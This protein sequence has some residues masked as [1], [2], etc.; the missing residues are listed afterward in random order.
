MVADMWIARNR[1]GSLY[2]YEAEPQRQE[3]SFAFGGERLRLS[4]MEYLDVTWENSPIELVTKQTTI[5]NNRP[6]VAHKKGD[7]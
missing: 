6:Y 3:K 2:V 1:D 7:E 4:A 5:L